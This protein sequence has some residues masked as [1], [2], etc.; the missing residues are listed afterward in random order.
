M[1]YSLLIAVSSASFVLFL[2]W[3]IVSLIRRTKK[4]RWSFLI[5][6]LSLV[7]LFIVT[8]SDESKPVSKRDLSQAQD[9]VSSKVSTEDG[10]S[11]PSYSDTDKKTALQIE[12][13]IYKYQ[14]EMDPYERR[15]A[16]VFD[17]IKA[18]EIDDSAIYK[19]IQQVND[20]YKETK[21]NINSIKIPDGLHSDLKDD[22]ENILKSLN[23][24]YTSRSLAYGYLSKYVKE[25]DETHIDTVNQQ[26]MY[27]KDFSRQ[28]KMYVTMLF[29]KT[30]L[31]DD[32]KERE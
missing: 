1:F 19:E 12:S 21:K 24:Y 32:L 22:L 13:V 27:A 25:S 14:K 29:G 15:G 20:K 9:D 7:I 30:G 31:P 3:G 28:Y 17:M 16:E 5:S 6:L 4:A 23:G 2:L 11:T 18:D 26:L 8:P 10:E